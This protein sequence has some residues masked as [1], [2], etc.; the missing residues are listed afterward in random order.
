[1]GA[2]VVPQP[3]ESGASAVCV[4]GLEKLSLDEG[5]AGE[6]PAEGVEDAKTRLL[7][8][9]DELGKAKAE[10]AR[11]NNDVEKVRSE[12]ELTEATVDSDQSSKGAA[13]ELL[14]KT[15]VS[16][17]PAEVLQVAEEQVPEAETVT[18]NESLSSGDVK[19]CKDEVKASY[20]LVVNDLDGEGQY[21]EEDDVAVQEFGGS[22]VSDSARENCGEYEDDVQEECGESDE[23]DVPLEGEREEGD[24]EESEKN[25]P[26]PLDDDED[27]RN[28]QYI[29]KRG[30]FYEHDDRGRDEG[31]APV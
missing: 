12:L 4:D 20:D 16:E 30:G 28:P 27:R 29:P 15:E 25:T 17:A 7:K 14:D 8:L 22:E 9:K 19:L 31:E 2:E 18:V 5:G 6:H 23:E 21:Q 1:M 3:A 24:G 10:L 11:A 26:K 13:D